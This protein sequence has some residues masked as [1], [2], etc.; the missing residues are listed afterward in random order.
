MEFDDLLVRAPYEDV[1]SFAGR[2]QVGRLELV[3]RAPRSVGGAYV[4][5]MSLSRT[6]GIPLAILNPADT[7]LLPLDL[8]PLFVATL[9][10]FAGL[11]GFRGFVPADAT[12][13]ASVTLP[14]SASL[15]GLRVFVGG[16]V[17]DLTQFRVKDVLP[18]VQ[19]TFP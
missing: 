10:P 13:Q 11:N 15:R 1:A 17:L 19:L 5:A 8:D 4:L 12:I 16:F 14:N 9:N 7:R 3:G 2:S 18:S 6:F